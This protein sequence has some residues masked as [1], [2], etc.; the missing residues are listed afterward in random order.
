MLV[1]NKTPEFGKDERTLFAPMLLS[2]LSCSLAYSC[3]LFPRLS[4]SL[5]FFFSLSMHQHR[6]NDRAHVA[7]C[8][9]RSQGQYNLHICVSIFQCSFIGQHQTMVRQSLPN[10]Y[11][12][13]IHSRPDAVCL[14]IVCSATLSF[15]SCL[16]ANGFSNGRSNALH[17]MEYN[18]PLYCANQNNT[19]FEQ[20][21]TCASFI[22]IQTGNG[23]RQPALRHMIFS[24]VN[25]AVRAA[26]CTF[27]GVVVRLFVYVVTYNISSFETL[28][29]SRYFVGFFLS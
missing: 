27:R 23:Q 26:S 3:S 1:D 14:S 2:M 17:A 8:G 11:F 24:L 22:H 13:A 29:Y 4:L 15:L 5:Y 28:R 16:S 25:A 10:Y 9:H 18:T 20:L 6:I 7:S 21:A 12:I 19:I